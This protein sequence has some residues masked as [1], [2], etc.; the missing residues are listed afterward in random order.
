MIAAIYARKSTEQSGVI[1]E[2]KSVTRQIEH[3]KAYAASKGWNVSEE[4]I[5]VD[6]GVSGAEF[7]K[8]PGFIRLMN[9]LKPR[10]TFHLLIMSEESRLGRES[11]ETSYALKQIM[12]AGIRVFFYLEDR[13]RTLDNALDK[14]LLSLTN[15]ASEMERERAKQRTYDAMLRK[16]KAGHVTGGK[17]FG[18]D[19]REIL[20]AEGRRLHVL[21]VINAAEAAVVR[22]IFEMFAGGV[23]IGRITKRL[24]E[25]CTPAPRQSP[26]GWAPTAVRE[27]IRRPLYKGEIVW[28]QH[29]KI[30]RGG[31]KKR[32]ER[33]EKDWIRLDAPDLRIISPEL[34]DSVAKRLEKRK[35]QRRSAF[36]DVESKYL[37]TGMARCAHCGGPMTIVGQDYHREKGRFYGCS[38]YKS[39]GS[40]ICKNSL[41]VEQELLDQTVLKAIEEALTEEMLKV[42][43]E[44]ALTKHRA[45]ASV[46]LDHRSRIEREL[47]LIEAQLKN[48]VDAVANGRKESA[49]FERLANEEERKRSLIADLE[50]LTRPEHVPHLDEARLKRELK[51]RFAD[52]R[53]LLGRHITS[54]RRLLRVLMERPLRLETMQDGDR[55]GYRVT[56][57]GSYLP[58][59]SETRHS[60]ESGVPNG[61]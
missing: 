50:R 20:S 29:E 30:V 59:L 57:T 26:R 16:A 51:A 58:L 19:N 40:S 52:T 32:R 43:I 47:S 53:A 54:A 7:V 60:V 9:A 39:R 15:F 11:I 24:N 46:Q 17:V 3:A 56:G 25:E 10:P 14:V 18:Y 21:R 45:G 5:F 1:E 36:R 2:E 42:A 55:K 31:T 8:R 4:H 33:N 49:L 28:N 48:L 13:E 6:D 37:L 23:G 38:Y 22:Q 61:I 27:I 41:L 35:G 12:D 34:W 44:K